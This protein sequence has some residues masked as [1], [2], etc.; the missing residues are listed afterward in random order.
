MSEHVHRP[1][2]PRIFVFGS[3]LL[4]AHVGGAAAYAARHC[5]AQDGIGQGP[6][7]DAYALPT[8]NA[9]GVPLTL[10]SVALTVGHFIAYAHAH[11]ELRF[12]VSEVGCG[13][14]GFKP[15]DVAPLFL[16]APP[17]CDLP[18]GWRELAA[19]AES[20]RV[21]RMYGADR[22]YSGDPPTGE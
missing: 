4:G 5:G 17:N 3:N 15:K 1:G 20:R 21:G 6:M 19:E 16:G 13:I 2:D 8:C 18:P 10:A 9:P 12:F 14:A 22:D 11:P 7:G